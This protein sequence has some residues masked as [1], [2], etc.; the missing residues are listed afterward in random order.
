MRSVDEILTDETLWTAR[1]VARYLRASRS[2]VYQ[3]AEGGTLPSLHI[4]GL[5]RFDPVQVRAFA[6]GTHCKGAVVPLRGS[7]V[8]R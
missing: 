7:Q 2:W 5:L 3:K 6:K 1:E 8:V 4:G